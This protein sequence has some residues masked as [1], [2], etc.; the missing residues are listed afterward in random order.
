[1]SER[2]ERTTPAE[3]G[4]EA[5]RLFDGGLRC[6]ESV[7]A[8]LA[9]RQG[10]APLGDLTAM[11]TGFCSGLSRTDGL[12]GAATGAVMAIGLAKGRRSAA[13]SAD[14]TYAAV[15]SLLAEFTNE[16]GSVSCPEL[17]GCSVATPEGRETY[18]ERGLIK[19]CRA[20]TQRA[21]EMAA[22][23]IDR[24]PAAPTRAS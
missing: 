6:A 19:R 1:M 3:A 16:F 23:L 22:E 14:E 2:E 15:R 11:A 8:A 18:R 13:D 9:R 21:T 5:A 7:V 17:I 4:A 24:E 10:A 12:C 20:L